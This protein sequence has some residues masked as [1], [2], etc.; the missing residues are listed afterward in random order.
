MDFQRLLDRTYSLPLLNRIA[1]TTLAQLIHLAF[2]RTA[3]KSTRKRNLES[4]KIEEIA[5]ELG[6]ESGQAVDIAASDGW[7]NSSLV[8]FF[9]SSNWTGLA[10]E[11]ESTR[12][13]KLAFNYKDFSEVDLFRGLVTPSSA[14]AL[15]T[16]SQIM[17]DFEILNLDIDSFDYFLLE[18]LLIAGYRPQI[19][20]VEF[21]PIFPLEVFFAKHFVQGPLWDGSDFYGCSLAAWIELLTPYD[22]QLVDIADNNAIFVRNHQLLTPRRASIRLKLAELSIIP[23]SDRMD[24]TRAHSLIQEAILAIVKKFEG[25]TAQFTIRPALARDSGL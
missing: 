7:T 13:F 18:S 17:S 6:M 1:K 2:V 8:N 12:F 20:S 9:S 24:L 19:A 25:S 21:N 11:V 23:R 16:A 4:R 3:L 22:Y 5:L 14:P 10:V 15:L